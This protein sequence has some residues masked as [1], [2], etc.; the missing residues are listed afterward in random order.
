MKILTK[1][2]FCIF[3]NIFI[4]LTHFGP[5][6][7]PYVCLN[8]VFTLTCPLNYIYRFLKLDQKK[9]RLY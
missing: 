4:L 2:L 5:V 7:E 1:I 8:Q 3:V 6:D 9:N